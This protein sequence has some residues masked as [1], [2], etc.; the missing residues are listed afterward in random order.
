[1]RVP[2]WVHAQEL[3]VKAGTASLWQEAQNNQMMTPWEIGKGQGFVS[4][5]VIYRHSVSKTVVIYT[6][7]LTETYFIYHS[8]MN[9]GAN[10]NQ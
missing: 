9:T 6:Y 2:I 8:R 10:K 3:P 7:S 4:V 5:A 1:M